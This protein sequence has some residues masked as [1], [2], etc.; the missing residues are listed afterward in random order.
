MN[1]KTHEK[2]RTSNKRTDDID[3]TQSF[4]IRITVGLRIASATVASTLAAEV[5]ETAADVTI[6]K[7]FLCT[8]ICNL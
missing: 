1:T 6:E 7:S 8:K 3:I 4:R 5:V 2:K